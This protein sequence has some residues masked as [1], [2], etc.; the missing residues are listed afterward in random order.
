MRLICVPVKE[1]RKK[2]IVSG[3]DREERMRWFCV[4]NPAEG[5]VERASGDC[6]WG[7]G[8]TWGEE[9]GTPTCHGPLSLMT[10]CPSSS[11]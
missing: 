5:A 1:R 10:S 6:C 8:R 2:R 7:M 3:E 4:T 11:T 9:K